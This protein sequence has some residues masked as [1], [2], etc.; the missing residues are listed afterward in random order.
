MTSIATAAG[1]SMMTLQPTTRADQKA[2]PS[3]QAPVKTQPETPTVKSQKV[4][5]RPEPNTITGR[6]VDEKGQPIA[7]AEAFLFRINRIDA[8]RKLSAKKL[9][10]AEGSYR[11]ENVIDIPKEF[12]DGKLFPVN[13]LE[14]EFVQVYVRAP[15]RVA[16][17]QMDMR[18]RIASTGGR[19]DMKLLPAATLS[20][21]VTGPDDK[22]VG[23]ALVTVGGIGY[24]RW[25]EV[26]SAR[27][28]ADG[29]YEINDVPAYSMVEYRKKEAEQ[30]RSMNAFRSGNDG[31]SSFSAYV[32]PPVV[33]VEHPDFAIK[34]ATYEKIPG[35]QDVKL[36]PAAVVEGRVVFGNSTKPARGAVVR[37]ESPRSNGLLPTLEQSMLQHYA[38]TR[39]DSGGK[40][41]FASVPAGNYKL[42]AELPDWVNVGIDTFVAAAGKTSTAPNLI[43]TKG[44]VISIR[45]VDDT[46]GKPIA[47]T[48]DTR[49]DI[50]AHSFPLNTGS[51]R[52][53]WVPTA[54]ANSAGRFELHALPGKRSILVFHVSE[55]EKFRWA[56]KSSTGPVKP[57]AVVDV[58]EGKTVEVDIP[59]VNH[60]PKVTGTYSPSQV[61]P[62]E[63]VEPPSKAKSSSV[64]PAKPPAIDRDDEHGSQMLRDIRAAAAPLLAK[65]AKEHGYGLKPGQDLVRVAPPF[66]PIRM[67]YYRVGHPTQSQA[68]RRGPSAM[69][70][71]WANGQLE[72]RGMTFGQTADSGY[73]L[74]DL[75]NAILGLKSQSVELAPGLPN[76]EMP[77]DY[78]VRTGVEKTALAKQ[79]EK[80]LQDELSIPVRLE[81]REV[82]RPVYVARGNYQIAPL[83]GYKAQ[84]TLILT[85]ETIT[86]DEIQI[87]GKQLVANSGAGGGTDHFD[88]F[89]DWLGRWIGKPI[90]SEVTKMPAN[91]LSWH[92]HERSPSTEQTRRE[93]HDPKLVLANITAQTGLT[94]EQEN[95][96][97]KILFVE[98]SAP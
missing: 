41:R 33:T 71:Y 29:T 56:G 61:A 45:L 16:A 46:T 26:A 83:P 43:L 98:R 81:F 49:A 82:I 35:T 80:I 27:T 47:I 73:D 92:L 14:E 42:S 76:T 78:V 50:A 89:L 36:L 52:P 79:L 93:D 58:I 57:H 1:L 3:Q 23:G 34:R 22:P 90:V 63:K 59:V 64:P 4:S 32:A 91:Q 44:G 8:S 12:P 85:D 19:F 75:L 5:A 74:L 69:L 54:V 88:V 62:A 65:M 84:G 96:P 18:Q 95:R 20:G 30:R 13:P 77:G 87:F 40:Y 17:M 21:R 31:A 68:I 9:T 38:N 97:V 6:A 37:L 66:A 24:S 55:G 7:G 2:P 11:F 94:F 86:T 72:N 70:F 39:T 60:E 53:T 48:P 10:D 51:N 67:E 15:G 28:E 25:D